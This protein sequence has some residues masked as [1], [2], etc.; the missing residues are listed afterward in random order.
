MRVTFDTNVLDRVVRPARFPKDPRRSE[1]LK[2]H[3]ALKSRQI[4]GF[5]CETLVTLEGIQNKDRG[6]VF[7]STTTRQ[8]RSE[9]ADAASGKHTININLIVEQ[10]KRQPLHPEAAARAQAALD[11][12]MRVISAPRIGNTRI[13]DPDQTIYVLE[14]D[15]ALVAARLDKFMEAASAIEARGLGAAQG[16]ELANKFAQRS[17]VTEHWYLS[18]QRAIDVHEERA[19]QRAIG[20]WADG[21]SIAAHIGYGIDSFC[22]EDKGSSAGGASILDGVNRAWLKSTYG[23]KILTLDDLAATI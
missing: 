6:A 18:L 2:I 4:E 23:V 3:E 22:T 7:G 19:V 16:L 15:A 20:E 5:F 8:Q 21:D 14:P 13:C 10:P 9:H 12:G 17:N 1:Y 11:I